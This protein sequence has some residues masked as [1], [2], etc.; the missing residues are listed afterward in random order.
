MSRHLRPRQSSIAS[1]SAAST[2]STAPR[3]PPPRCGRCSPE[4]DRRMQHEQHL[5]N[6]DDRDL[7]ER[8][9][10]ALVSDG[11]Y[12]QALGVLT[13]GAL[14]TGCALAL[15]ASPGYVGLL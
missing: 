1:R 5:P 8:G 12:S 15:G 7:T 2:G 6:A 4:W 13:G 14:L 3:T 11:I 10:A 9:L